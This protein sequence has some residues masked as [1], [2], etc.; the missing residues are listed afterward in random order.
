LRPRDK[1]PLTPHGFK[2]ATANLDQVETWWTEH[3]NANIGIPMGRLTNLLLLDLDFRQGSILAD[4]EDLVRLYGA[5]P[6]T[7]EVITGQGRHIYFHFGGAVPARIDKGI[8][9]KGDGGYGVMPPS[10]HPNGKIYEFDGERGWKALLHPADPPQWLLEAIANSRAGS[11]TIETTGETP[12]PQGE[13]NNRLTSF[14]GRLR[15]DGLGSEALEAALLIENRRRCSPPLPDDEVRRIAASIARYA[16]GQEQASGHIVGI[17]LT[18][19]PRT[20]ETLN[21]VPLLKGR[22]EFKWLRR[23][24]S[25][26]QAGF[27]DGTQAMWRNATEL[28]TFGRAQSALFEGTGVLIPTPSSRRIR[29]DWEPVAQMIRSIA[30]QDSIS[31]EPPLKDEFRQILRTTWEKADRPEA[32]EAGDPKQRRREFNTIL[33]ECLLHQRHHAASAPPRCC[34]WIGE[35]CCWVHQ[36]SLLEWLSTPVAKSKHYAWED[37][38]VALFLLDFTPR[39]LHR[40]LD[41]IGIHVRVWQGPLDLLTDDET[42]DPES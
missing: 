13:R 15:R 30:D 12:W 27:V 8:D 39:D 24:G 6:D 11:K 1:K 18:D 32:K 9:L 40:S 26:I 34:V 10:I 5:V 16:E 35:Q 22:L 19:L 31:A 14:G 41:G 37:V 20:I 4:R 2:D 25:L 3:P 36:E 29:K 42:E 7:A 33:R 23:R 28:G 17:D 38:R 21:K